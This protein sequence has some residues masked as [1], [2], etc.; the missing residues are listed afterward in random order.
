M[1]DEKTI[2]TLEHADRKI[3]AEM[4][5]DADMDDLLDAFYGLC[6]GVTWRANT[7]LEAMKQY[8]EDRLPPEER[9]DEE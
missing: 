1:K 5:W 4:S 2:L 7:V 9:Y 6:V 3:V 8:A